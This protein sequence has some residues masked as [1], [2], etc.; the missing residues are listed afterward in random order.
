MKAILYQSM[1]ERNRR[2][3]DMIDP[4]Q[5]HCNR[6]R[7]TVIGELLRLYIQ[8]QGGIFYFASEYDDICHGVDYIISNDGKNFVGVDLCVGSNIKEFEENHSQSTIKKKIDHFQKKE[9]TPREFFS[10][11]LNQR[12][13]NSIP[14]II[15]RFDKSILDG[16]IKD[17]F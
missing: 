17:F 1:V 8:S 2:M 3:H 10:T 5:H 4:E 15:L 12:E 16:L 9:G 14:L 6:L 11:V 7:E 13:G